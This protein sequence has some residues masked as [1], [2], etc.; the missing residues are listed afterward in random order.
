MNSDIIA[1]RGMT[2]KKRNKIIIAILVAVIAAFGIA[3]GVTV[4]TI[5]E[6]L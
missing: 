2:M 4:N 1:K 3:M 5:I 6:S